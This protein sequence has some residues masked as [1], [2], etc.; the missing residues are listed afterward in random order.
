LA[1][2]GTESAAADTAANAAI[3]EKFIESPLS[4]ESVRTLRLS[5]YYGNASA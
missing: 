3:L 4:S 5:D 1:D 2:A